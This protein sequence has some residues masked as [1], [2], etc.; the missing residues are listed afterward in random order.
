ML[1][2][3]CDAAFRS[4]NR[5]Q[6]S[7]ARAD[8]KR[9][10]RAAYKSKIEDHFGDNDM[11]YGWRGVL[12][13]TSPATPRC[14]EGDA[15]LMDKLTN[16]PVHFEVKRPEAAAARTLDCNSSSLVVQEHELRCTLRTVSLPD[17]TE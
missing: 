9:S 14:S 5:V 10:I 4:G 17:W 3:Q 7:T 2:R 13:L 6:Y 8:L 16:F 1:L 12:D 15:V 11:R